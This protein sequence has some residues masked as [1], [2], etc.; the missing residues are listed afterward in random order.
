ME[1][2]ALDDVAKKGKNSEMQV[3]S[4]TPVPLT[5]P[6]FQGTPAPNACPILAENSSFSLKR[7][8]GPSEPAIGEDRPQKRQKTGLHPCPSAVHSKV[9]ENSTTAVAPASV[10]PQNHVP[11]HESRPTS[12]LQGPGDQNHNRESRFEP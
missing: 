3:T 5:N 12:T 4:E 10:E 7:K 11:D 2:D 9:V 8:R 6:T 1:S